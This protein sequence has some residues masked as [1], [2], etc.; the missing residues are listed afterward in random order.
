[1]G[2]FKLK[3][4]VGHSPLEV[5]AGALLGITVGILFTPLAGA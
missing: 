1:M 4:L 3:E 2:D 5:G